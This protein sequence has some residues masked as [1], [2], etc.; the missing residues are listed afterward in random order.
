MTRE[1]RVA[2]NPQW[3]ID[4]SFLYKRLFE[5]EQQDISRIR[6][7]VEAYPGPL[8]EHRDMRSRAYLALVRHLCRFPEA[9]CM[10]WHIAQIPKETDKY[11]L[12]NMMTEIKDWPYMPPETDISPL[13]DCTQSDKWLV[14]DSAICALS[15]CDC[16]EARLAI[17]PFLRREPIRKNEP[18]YSTVLYTIQKIGT[19][20]DIPV[21]ER[22]SLEATR[23]IKFCIEL[24]IEAI[25]QRY[26][27]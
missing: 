4:Y 3:G 7:I 23:N 6:Q 10:R 21:L 2:Q 17:R 9:D 15:I 14:Y 8:P 27:I 26:Q 22:L 5:F 20:D 24:A 1:E 18:I 11:I 25:K 12:N 13:L 16:E 19:P